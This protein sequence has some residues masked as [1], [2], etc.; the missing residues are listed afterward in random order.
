[1]FYPVLVIFIGINHSA[2]KTKGKEK[3]Q[4]K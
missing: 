2:Q 3:I 4:L 1:M